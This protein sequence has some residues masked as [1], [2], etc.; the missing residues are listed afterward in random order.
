MNWTTTWFPGGTFEV[1][2]SAVEGFLAVPL[3]ILLHYLNTL[4][5]VGPIRTTCF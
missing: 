5:N 3:H 1:V 4:K 2:K